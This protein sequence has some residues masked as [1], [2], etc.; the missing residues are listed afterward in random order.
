[1]FRRFQRLGLA[2]LLLATMFTNTPLVADL[3]TTTSVTNGLITYDVD[4][5]GP[6]AGAII[7]HP[8][9]TMPLANLA[10]RHLIFPKLI[11]AGR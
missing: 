4:T 1:M 2:A 10:S 6:R 3:F 7:T 8:G 5:E 9:T 11:L